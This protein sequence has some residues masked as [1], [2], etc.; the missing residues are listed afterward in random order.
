MV[1]GGFPLLARLP[2]PPPPSRS[3]GPS[4]LMRAT[5]TEASPDMDD[6]CGGLGTQTEDSSVGE[7]LGLGLGLGR[8][9]HSNGRLS[10]KDEG[11]WRRH[12]SLELEPLVPPALSCCSGP[13]QVDRGLGKSM[14]VQ[15]LMQTAPGTAHDAHHSL[16]SPSPSTC[17]DSP[18]GFH[19]CSQ[20]P[21]GGGRDGRIRRSG[22]GGWGEEDLF[23]SDRDIETQGFDFLSQGTV[24]AHTYS[25]ELLRTGGRAGTGSRGSNRSLATGHASS[26]SAGSTELLNMPHVRLK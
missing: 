5:S 6:F 26:P 14:S 18:V 8:L 19:S 20:D 15:N 17:S 12:M 11:S 16:S 24:E 2:P 25:S 7:D 1:D 9:G 21:G 13:S 3:G 4:S 22:G 23:I 10:T